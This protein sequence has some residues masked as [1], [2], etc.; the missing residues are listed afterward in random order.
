LW[1]LAATATW[2]A[3]TSRAIRAAEPT[4]PA[5]TT[6][7]RAARP[8]TAAT[9]TA[10]TT[11]HPL[12][13]FR[14][15]GQFGAVEFAIAIGVELHG[16]LDKPLIR[17][18]PARSAT[19]RSATARSAALAGPARSAAFAEATRA[20]RWAIAF[21][22]LGNR[23]SP[24]RRGDHSHGYHHPDSRHAFHERLLG[25]RLLQRIKQGGNA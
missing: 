3:T 18:R 7:T 12:H 4:R 14:E 21:G 2:A 20:F 8:T 6:S 23:E 9:T 19:A 11:T 16:M 5:G 25:K 24:E 10:R 13:L 15:L 17:G 1:P 22:R